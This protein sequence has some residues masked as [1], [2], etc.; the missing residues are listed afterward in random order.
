MMDSPL[1]FSTR[2]Y[3]YMLE[4]ICQH[5]PFEKGAVEVKTFPDGERYQRILSEVSEREV[6]LIGGTHSDADTLELYDL[7]CSMAKFGARSL[8]ML[9]PYFAYSTM[10][11][12]VLPGEVITSK[13]RA[14]LFS[15][16]P[17]AAKSNRVVLMDLHAAGLT[18]YFEGSIV[19]THL[20]AKPVILEACRRLG[21]DNF[22][23][24]S[25]DAGRAKW[26]ESLANDL[27]VEAAFVFKRRLDGHTTEFKAMN[28]EVKGA[29][30]IIYD[31]MIRTG[32]SLISAAKAYRMAGATGISAIATHA[33]LPG[34]ALERLVE[35]DLFDKIILT[36]THP[37]AIEIEH[38]KVEVVSVSG[39][40]ADWL[41]A[42]FF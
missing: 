16:I 9:V 22:V 24:A 4:R 14:R 39:I 8:T 17:P 21:G 42:H 41:K 38:P 20:Y 36:D 34:N 6:V 7:A 30:V 33:I 5:H 37:R 2:S 11:R 27:H 23:L 3:A 25:T 26:V 28:A 29:Q 31:D 35:S 40:L 18:Y 1:L 15:S 13:S 32:G 12:G 10:E 19:P